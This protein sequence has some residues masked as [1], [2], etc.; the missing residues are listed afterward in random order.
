MSYQSK[1]P[2]TKERIS[3]FKFEMNDAFDRSVANYFLE[4]LHKGK[5][6]IIIIGHQT[7]LY[8]IQKLITG[9][10]NS[11]TEVQT[12]FFFS[13]D[14]KSSIICDCILFF[15]HNYNVIPQNFY[16]F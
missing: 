2:A 3:P 6:D 8:N 4:M 16:L 5:Q 11:E 13:N 1:F 14:K 15:Y 10:P 7:E 9:K 12:F